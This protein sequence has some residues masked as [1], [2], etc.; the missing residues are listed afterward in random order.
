MLELGLAHY[1]APR[2]VNYYLPILKH[3]HITRK[4]THQ[5]Q[6]GPFILIFREFLNSTSHREQC[7]GNL[8]PSHSHKTHMKLA[9]VTMG[10][11]TH[12]VLASVTIPWEH[13]LSQSIS[14]SLN[15]I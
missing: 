15:L 10:T 12:E 1:S 13:L 8:F 6:L 14:Y 9:S 2:F 4:Y 5:Y 11:F 3:I 7:G